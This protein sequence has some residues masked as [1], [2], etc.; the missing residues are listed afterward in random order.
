MGAKTKL[1]L[2][3]KDILKRIK[4][5]AR[6]GLTDKDIAANLG[7]SATYFCA[8]KGKNKD[9]AEAIKSGRAPVDIIVENMI[10]KKA[11]GMSIKTQQAV[12]LRD[13]IYNS[14]GNKS[15]I[16]RVEIVTLT[17]EIPPDTT[18][19]IFWLKNRKPDQWNKPTPK[20]IDADDI[21]KDIPKG[22]KIDSW[23]KKQIEE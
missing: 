15:V 12:K 6:D 19:G 20:P 8:L 10:F 11:V 5:W 23:I 7:Y 1:D 2:S 9:V 17:Q 21:P 18:A 13:V 4:G 14:E 22:V 16:E 3:D